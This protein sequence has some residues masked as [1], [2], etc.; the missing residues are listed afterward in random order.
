MREEVARLPAKRAVPL[1]VSSISVPSP[2]PRY[3]SHVRRRR[4]WLLQRLRR[5]SSPPPLPLRRC[6]CRRLRGRIRPSRR[7][8]T[9]TRGRTDRARPSLSRRRPQIAFH[10]Y[11]LSLVHFPPPHHSPHEHPLP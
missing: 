4:S 7:A 8:S 6:R 3:R 2:R 5:T 11:H 9:T 1:L 10:P